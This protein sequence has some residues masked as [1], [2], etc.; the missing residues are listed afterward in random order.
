MP[1]KRRRSPSLGGEC[2]HLDNN[3]APLTGYQT[4]PFELRQHIFELA[5]LAPATNPASNGG[6]LYDIPT[7]LSLSLVIKELNEKARPYLWA[8]IS[9]TRPSALYALREAI[10]AHPERGRLIRHLHIGSQTALPPRWWPLSF[11][12]LDGEGYMPNS[13][14]YIGRPYNWLAS[15]LD[16]ADLPSGCD[17]KQQAHKHNDQLHFDGLFRFEKHSEESS[18]RKIIDQRS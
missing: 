17:D 12:W 6:P 1:P 16:Q 14:G 10:V 2:H 15:S 18:E 9:I 7:C 5:C 8:Q 11:A 13:G 3:I 4:L